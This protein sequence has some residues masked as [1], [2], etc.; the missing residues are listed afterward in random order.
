MLVSYVVFCFL[1]II[2]IILGTLACIIPGIWMQLAWWPGNYLIIDKKATAFSAFGKAQQITKG[3]LMNSLVIG[4]I[5]FAGQIVG[6]LLCCVGLF[7]TVPL[8]RVFAATAYGMLAGDQV[9]SQ[10]A[11]PDVPG[12]DLAGDNPFA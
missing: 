12:S 5:Y 9:T 2:L 10:A 4:L 7:F 6:F 8:I 3:N 11:K 1:E